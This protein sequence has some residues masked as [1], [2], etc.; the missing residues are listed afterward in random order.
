VTTNAACPAPLLEE[1]ARPDA[2]G[3][4][5]IRDAADAMRLTARGFHRVLKVARTLADL[6]GE[7]QVRRIHLAEAL[8][9]RAR[10]KGGRCP[11]KPLCHAIVGSVWWRMRPRPGAGAPIQRAASEVVMRPEFAPRSGGERPFGPLSAAWAPLKVRLAT[12]EADIRRAQHLRY[13]VFYEEKT[14]EPT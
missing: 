1:I 9:Y 11:R 8:S 4:K 6:D 5:L 7:E 2:D 12:S 3:T 10:A 13:A 14:A